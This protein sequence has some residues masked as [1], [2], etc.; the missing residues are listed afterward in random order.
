MVFNTLFIFKPWSCNLHGE[1]IL[2]FKQFDFFLKKFFWYFKSP[3]LHGSWYHADVVHV[4][5]G[6]IILMSGYWMIDKESSLVKHWLEFNINREVQWQM[7]SAKV[8]RGRSWIQ[9]LHGSQI[10]KEKGKLVKYFLYYFIYLT[11]TMI[12]RLGH[13]MLSSNIW[14]EVYLAKDIAYVAECRTRTRMHM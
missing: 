7:V 2:N 9:G 11:V 8:L 13:I 5:L 12:G 3:T 6:D 14:S 4:L 10:V 1:C